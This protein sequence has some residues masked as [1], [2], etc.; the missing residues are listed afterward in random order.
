LALHD[1]DQSEYQCVS[2]STIPTGLAIKGIMDPWIITISRNFTGFQ[3]H[4]K[5]SRV[6]MGGR[7]LTHS[8]HNESLILPSQLK[9]RL[10]K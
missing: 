10:A 3:F 5:I 1:Q 7:L 2:E 4:L 6:H 8:F 9:P